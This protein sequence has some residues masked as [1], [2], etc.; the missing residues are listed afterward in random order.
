M[1]TESV[2]SDMGIGLALLFSVVTVLAAA[3][4]VAVGD[5]L[6]TAAGFAVAVVA[7]SFAVV[8]AQAFW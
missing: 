2:Q 5:Q 6:A 7:A 4:M 8:A 3:G 1:Q